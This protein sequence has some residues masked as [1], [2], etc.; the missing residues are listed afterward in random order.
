MKVVFL[1]KEVLGTV[2]KRM[3]SDG[4]IVAVKKYNKIE[5]DENHV[6]QFISEV[7]ILSQI[8]HRHIVKLLGCCLETEVPLLVY[9][10][11]SNGTLTNEPSS[12]TK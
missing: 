9:E 10:Y 12:Q 4:S 3:L 11:V 8:S 5:D 7:L 6:S 1:G 2:Y